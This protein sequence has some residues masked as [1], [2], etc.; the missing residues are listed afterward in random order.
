MLNR[1]EVARALTLAGYSAGIG[2]AQAQRQRDFGNVVRGSNFITP[3]T[4]GHYRLK[5][6]PYVIIE[7]ALGEFMGSDMIGLTVADC[8]KRENCYDHNGSVNT[9]DEMVAHLAKLESAFS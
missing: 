9:L 3:H 5:A 7:V 2:E 8:A 1:H 4:V 6:K